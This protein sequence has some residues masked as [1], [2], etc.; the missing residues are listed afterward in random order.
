[1]GNAVCQTG[2]MTKAPRPAAAGGPEIATLRIELTD[3]EPLIWR[4]VT[5]PVSITLKTLHDIVQAAMGWTDSHLWIFTFGR[6][7][8]GLPSRDDWRDPPLIN[9]KKTVLQDILKPRKT[10]IQYLYDFGDS[11]EHA[12]TI[13]SRRASEVG[14]SYPCYAGGERN[15]PLDD[16]GGIPGFYDALHI[17]ANPKHP[18]FEEIKAWFGDYDPAV[19][20]KRAIEVRLGKI[21][22]RIQKAK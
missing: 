7:D 2:G 9:A 19:I 1:M 12:L 16:C 22:K 13:S 5:I 14:Q 21:A 15:A 11:W 6:A 18:D 4:E 10:N 8:Y 20:D 17:L 3:T